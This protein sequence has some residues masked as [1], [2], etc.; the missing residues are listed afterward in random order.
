MEREKIFANYI[1]DE[2]LVSRVYEES[3]QFNIKK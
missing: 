2:G 1:S 3:L